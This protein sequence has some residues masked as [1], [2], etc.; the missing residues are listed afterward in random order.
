MSLLMGVVTG[1]LNFQLV[2]VSLHHVPPLLL[3]SSQ[4]FCNTILQFILLK[5][6]LR[7]LIFIH[8]H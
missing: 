5:S 4:I 7:D 6:F 1:L 8:A 3:A 2:L